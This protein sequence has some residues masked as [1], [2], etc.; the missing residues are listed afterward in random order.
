MKYF[1]LQWLIKQKADDIAMMD[2]YIVG[3]LRKKTK[4]L[5]CDLA[6]RAGLRKLE[7]MFWLIRRLD[8]FID[9]TFH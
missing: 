2:C 1:S 9:I 7:L 3:T 5:N 4:I 8:I 6:K